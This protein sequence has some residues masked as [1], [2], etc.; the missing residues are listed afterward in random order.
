MPGGRDLVGAGGGQ[1]SEFEGLGARLEK[2]GDAVDDLVER[3]AWAE[4]GE[5]M[6]FFD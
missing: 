3:Y 2:R 6:E 4:A 5:S 1:L